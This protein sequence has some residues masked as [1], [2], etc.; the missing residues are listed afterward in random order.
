MREELRIA[1]V[2]GLLGGFTTFSAFGYETFA[3]LN[4]GQ[5][6][7]AAINVVGSILAGLFAVWLGYRMVQSLLGV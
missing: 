2:V 6:G 3:L 5:L 1:L 4:N 7:R